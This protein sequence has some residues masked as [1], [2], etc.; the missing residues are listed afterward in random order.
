MIQNYDGWTARCCKVLVLA[1]RGSK[2]HLR[3]RWTC[4]PPKQIA[5]NVIRTIPPSMGVLGRQYD[6][7]KIDL[8]KIHQLFSAYGSNNA[9]DKKLAVPEVP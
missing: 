8:V 4:L 9:V 1:E 6:S 7:N 2:Y 5:R 3:V